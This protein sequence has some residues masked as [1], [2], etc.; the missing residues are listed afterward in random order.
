MTA[1][2]FGRITAVSLQNL[3]QVLRK[4]P[5]KYVACAFYTFSFTLLLH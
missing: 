2:V 4:A 3:M 1:I 5:I